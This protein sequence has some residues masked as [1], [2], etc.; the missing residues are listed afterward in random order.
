LPQ[1]KPQG[2]P[3]HVRQN[4]KRIF[5][6]AKWEIP[7][8]NWVDLG[9]Q[10]YGVSLLNN[11]KY[12]YDIQPDQIRLT[13]LRGSTWPDP[14]ADIGTHYFS[15]GIYP[16]A[17]SWK[18]ANV[19][20]RGYEFN[21]ALRVI[22][23]PD[24]HPSQTDKLSCGKGSFFDLQSDHLILMALKQSESDSQQWIFRCYE[25]HGEAETLK[26][27]NRLNLAIAHPV[28]LLEQPIG[29]S[30]QIQPWQVASFLMQLN[31][32]INNPSPLHKQ[33]Q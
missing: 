13:L 19:V 21:Q 24:V 16:H 15:Y 4:H 31:R 2:E 27:Q 5:E 6:K 12:G 11:C 3:C 29:S 25:C 26:L 22:F 17:G 33:R 10:E 1:Q 9:D 18:T 14:E 20:Q 23:N 28:N 8:L 30:S 7:A 32:E